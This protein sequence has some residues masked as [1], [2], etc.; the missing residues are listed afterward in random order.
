VNSV[1]ENVA[2][3]VNCYNGMVGTKEIAVV[4]DIMLDLYDQVHVSRISPEFPIPVINC[5]GDEAYVVRP[6]GAGNV[7]EQFRNFDANVSLYSFLDAEASKS[8]SK[9]KIN[10]KL[11]LVFDCKDVRVPV[12]RRYYDGD[13]PLVRMDN[14][15]KNYGM[16]EAIAG[17]RLKLVKKFIDM[18]EKKRPDVVVFSDYN[19]GIFCPLTS[20]TLIDHCRKL[21]I[22]TIV[23]PKKDEVQWRG[24]TVFKPNLAEASAFLQ[25]TEAWIVE[26]WQKST[27][28]LQ[29]RLQCESVVITAG[30]RG[31]FV[32]DKNEHFTYKPA[33][34]VGEVRS[35]IGAGDCFVAILALATAH[36][37]TA[38]NAS[39]VAYEAGAVYVQN[40]HNEPI[41]PHQLLGRVENSYSKILCQNDLAKYIKS[42]SDKK[43][44]FVNGCFDILHCGHISTLEFAKN[45]GDIL[46]VATNTDESIKRLK[47]ASRPIND[48]HDRR[49]MLASLGCVDFVTHFEEDTPALL[50]Q[51]LKPHV[52]VKGNQYLVKDVVGNDTCEVIL[53]PMESGLST[54]MLIEKIKS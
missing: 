11:S 33:R 46:V 1:A 50:I 39:Q 27:S 6:G 4:G 10:D 28:E 9:T 35:V 38:I 7:C 52:I 29:E 34:A 53:A 19:K 3:F 23:D 51:K 12:K 22:P 16:G 20:S 32:L 41:W 54:T 49:I 21:G 44:V 40:K 2:D 17:N 25:K 13:Y 8:V 43:I 5:Q 30:S 45:H 42:K 14:E 26:N 36:Q 18:T 48:L 31:V 47:G 15:K 37:Y 24:C